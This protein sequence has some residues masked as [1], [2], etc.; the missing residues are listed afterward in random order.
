MKYK[1]ERET[2]R[3]AD[4]RTDRQTDRKIEKEREREFLLSRSVSQEREGERERERLSPLTPCVTFLTGLQVGVVG[5]S[6]GDTTP[7][8]E[9]ST[10][11]EDFVF[12]CECDEDY[13]SRSDGTCGMWE[14]K[15]MRIIISRHR[16]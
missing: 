4:R 2:E 14:K 10:C 12:Q 8:V 9:H 16:I 5:V 7:C 13:A 15:R 3:Q 11:N 1:R 6:C